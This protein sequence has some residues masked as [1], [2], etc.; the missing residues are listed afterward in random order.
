MDKL[1]KIRRFVAVVSVLATLFMIAFILFKLRANDLPGVKVAKLPVQVDISLQK[2]HYTETKEGKKRWDLTADRAEYNKKADTTSLT[3]VRFA[4]A[5]NERT[6]E[7][8]VTA[9][10]ADYNNSTRDL[11]LTGEVHGTSSK[12]L[13]FFAPSVS[14]VAARSLIKSEDRVRLVDQGLE[15]EGVGMELLTQSRKL[16]LL[17]E[18]KAVYRPGRGK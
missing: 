6:G 11:T 18:V 14:Y 5:G 16:R 7:L 8:L 15:L 2:V 3:G 17:S 4:V 1:N 10:R 9:Q 13:E 12:G